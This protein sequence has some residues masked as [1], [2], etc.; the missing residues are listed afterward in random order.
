MS[1]SLNQ[2]SLGLLIKTRRKE[3]ALTQEV[4]AMLCGVT[5]KTLIRVEKGEDVYISTVFKILDGLGIRLSV[6]SKSDAGS[7]E[8]Y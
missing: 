5:K 4:A 2:D 8:W 7:S 3:A 6:E 1:S